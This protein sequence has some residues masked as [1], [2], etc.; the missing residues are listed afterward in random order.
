[1]G[2]GGFFSGISGAVSDIFGGMDKAAGE[3]IKAE[4]TELDAEGMRLKSHGD[5][6]SA[7]NYDLAS[8]L[9]LQNKEFTRESTS[10]QIAQQQRQLYLGL[11]ATR[12]DVAA[13]G[14]SNSG[15]ALDIMRSS[16]QQGALAKGVLSEQGLISEAGF[17]E[18]ATSYTNLSGAA[19]YAASVETDMAAKEDHIAGEQ[20]D[21]AGSMESHGFISGALKGAIGIASLFI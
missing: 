1:M 14:F 2:F 17:Q 19:R 7:D 4:G 18:Q 13:S 6:V 5:L 21:L 20:R 10:I 15:S 9:A 3:R 11:G 8:T 12:A 16:A